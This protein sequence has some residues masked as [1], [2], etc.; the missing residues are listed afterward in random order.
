M[1]KIREHGGIKLANLA[2]KSQSAQAKW[3]IQLLRSEL[4]YFLSTFRLPNGRNK[5]TR[6]NLFTE[7]L[8]STY[9]ENI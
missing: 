2:I 9:L 3:L 6:P 8:F 5:R 1:W 4:K 7:I